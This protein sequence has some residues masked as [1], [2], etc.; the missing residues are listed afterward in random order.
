[1]SQDIVPVPALEQPGEFPTTADRNAGTYNSK[2]I[3]WA[4]RLAAFGGS[5]W[6][7][8]Q[9]AFTNA[10]VAKAS[11]QTAV[12]AAANAA[13]AQDAL[14]GATNFKGL[15]SEQVGVL[16]KPATVKDDGRFWLLLR[17]VA[18]VTQEKP[19]QSD[20]WASLDAGM[21]PQH[22]VLEGTVACIP[23]VTYIIAGAAVTLTAPATGL[24]N[25][26]VFAFRLAAAVS[27]N[28]LVNFGAL[29]VRGQTAGLRA[30]DVPAFGLDLEY[31]NGGW[32]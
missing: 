20:A 15:W 18:D 21:R 14:W 16:N 2:A 3:G 1:M 30:I 24:Q 12:Q 29:L 25:G 26:D 22:T 23:G 32:V 4:G 11:A 19:G 13:S 31:S 9:S 8:A 10:G 7:I 6:A 28:Q 17:S 27:G 5:I